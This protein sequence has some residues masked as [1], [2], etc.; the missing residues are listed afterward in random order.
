MGAIAPI[1]VKGVTTTAWP[2]SAKVIKA[3]AISMSNLRGLFMLTLVM[4][5]GESANSSI[6]KPRAIASMFALSRTRVSPI[7]IE[8]KILSE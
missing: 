8:K 2:N 1:S 4:Q 7:D 5:L 6:V 3:S